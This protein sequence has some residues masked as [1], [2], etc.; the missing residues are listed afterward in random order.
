MRLR[1]API[2]HQPGRAL[3]ACFGADAHG[4][5]IHIKTRTH[6]ERKRAPGK[7]TCCP[8]GSG[9][10]LFEAEAPWAESLLDRFASWVGRFRI[11]LSLFEKALRAAK[12]N[13]RRWNSQIV[14][15]MKKTHLP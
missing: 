14:G 1:H 11:R 3:I 4:Q 6:K 7:C 2:V 9:R 12:L 10:V 15:I 13:Q 5:R 8:P